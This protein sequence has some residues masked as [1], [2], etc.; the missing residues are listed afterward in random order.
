MI[1]LTLAGIYGMHAAATPMRRR[2]VVGLAA[3][4]R[5]GPSVHLG[6]RPGATVE[7]DTGVTN[8]RLRAS[9]LAV[10]LGDRGFGMPTRYT[11][12]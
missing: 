4:A 9:V 5:P 12:R 3:C 10:H 7:G 6:E 11:T 2:G 8:G 1:G